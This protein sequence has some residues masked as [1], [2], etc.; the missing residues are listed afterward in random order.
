M[1]D[2]NHAIVARARG[3]LGTRFHHQGRLKRT[4]AHKG[5]VDC[6]GLLVGV[7]DELQLRDVHGLLLSA[8][9][10]LD[11]SHQPD[12]RKL[13]RTLDTILLPVSSEAIMP[14]DIVLLRVE[15]SPQHLAIVS[16]CGGKLGIIHA[17]APA[18]AVVEHPLD[19]LWQ[20]R[21]EAAYR[22]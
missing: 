12:S 4:E 1:P 19:D 9:D 21:I 3:W 7:A 22:I 8:S 6:L 15:H 20:G 16:D 2:V 13:K 17:F 11:Y 5:G 10:E 18:R 14:G